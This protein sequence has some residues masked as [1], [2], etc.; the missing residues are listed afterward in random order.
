MLQLHFIPMVSHLRDFCPKVIPSHQLII[1]CMLLNAM[2]CEYRSVNV[3]RENL[4]SPLHTIFAP[5]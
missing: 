3:L 4:V 1:A 5:S 2:Q